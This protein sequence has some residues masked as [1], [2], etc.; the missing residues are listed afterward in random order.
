MSDGLPLLVLVIF[1]VLILMTF[2]RLILM[3]CVAA[4]LA[5]FTVGLIDVVSWVNAAM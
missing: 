3:L 5:I 1:G 4:V 2:W